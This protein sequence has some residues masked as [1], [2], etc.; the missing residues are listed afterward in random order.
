MHSQHRPP[1]Q[2]PERPPYNPQ[3]S[4]G[5]YSR[6]PPPGGPGPVGFGQNQVQRP[7]GPP[8][9]PPLGPHPGSQGPL[10]GHQGQYPPPSG[11]RNVQCHSYFATLSLVQNK[12]G[13]QI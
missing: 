11:V 12:L 4:S 1:D 9:G 3:L 5:P 13:A 2:R 6:P 8:L 10:F 7:R